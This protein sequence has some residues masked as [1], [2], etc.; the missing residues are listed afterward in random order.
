MT[1]PQHS[2]A[3]PEAQG[4]ESKHETDHVKETPSTGDQ[5]QSNVE[6]VDPQDTIVNPG[7]SALGSPIL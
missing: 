4:G 1:M 7:E 5:D 6:T 3:A 2:E